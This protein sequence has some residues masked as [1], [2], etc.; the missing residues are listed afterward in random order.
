MRD[1][2]PE[3]HPVQAL[4]GVERLPPTQARRA[5]GRRA[6]WLVGAIERR[7]REGLAVELYVEE[8]AAIVMAVEAMR[9]GE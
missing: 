3:D 4:R 8:L 2:W 9:R 1:P 5:L 6:Q 7:V